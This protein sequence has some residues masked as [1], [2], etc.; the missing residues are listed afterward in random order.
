M[1]SDPRAPIIH[2]T[3][4]LAVKRDALVAV[5]G[6]GQ[7]TLQDK[8]LKA[9]ARKVRRIPGKNV[10]AG[11]AGATAD[12]LT[13][14]DLFEGKLQEFGDNLTRASVEVARTWRTDKMLRHLQAMM[15]VAD[16][17]RMF[18]LSGNGDVIEPD[19]GILSVGSGSVAAQASARA[20]LRHTAMDAET[21]ARTA[22]GIAA[23]I[24][25][26]TNDRIVVEVLG[27]KSS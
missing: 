21:V 1:L 11:F 17:E 26:Y 5:A 7:V 8:I 4:I 9:S 25:V 12:A 6:D 2:G 23:E 16:A 22:L 15:I 10:V 13:L 18:L 3:T 19:E 20:L 24:D 27:G 14:F